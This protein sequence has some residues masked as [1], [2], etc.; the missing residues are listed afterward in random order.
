MQRF[1]E[2]GTRDITIENLGDYSDGV[3]AA[4]AARPALSPLAPP[5]EEHLAKCDAH[6]A[7]KKAARRVLNRARV[8]Y[9]FVDAEF[10]GVVKAT[11]GETYHLAGKDELAEPYASFFGVVKAQDIIAFGE[12]KATA[13]GRN[14]VKKEAEILGALTSESAKGSVKGLI[15][16]MRD[17]TAHLEEAGDLRE[18]AAT[19]LQALDI[20]R[21]KLIRETLTLIGLTEVGILTQ[22]PRRRDLVDAV[23]ALSS[24]ST[25]KKPREEVAPDTSAVELPA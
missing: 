2:E 3:L 20:E 9:L 23:L 5:W 17:A 7:K 6:E 12:A 22:Y 19:A 24:Q 14:M 11:S 25:K 21:R 4:L 15:E 8:G 10:D 13:Y 18:D 16:G 1:T